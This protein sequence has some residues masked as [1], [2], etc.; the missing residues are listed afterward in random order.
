[1]DLTSRSALY[2]TIADKIERLILTEE[3][4]TDSKMPSE[5]YLADSFGVSR[6]VIREAL[7]LLRERGLITSRQGAATVITEPCTD[8]LARNLN[9]IILMKNV[10]PMQVY[11]IRMV[12]EMMSIHQAA[13]RFTEKDIEELCE[14]NGDMIKSKSDRTLRAELDMAFHKRIADIAENPLLSMMLDAVGTLMQPLIISNLEK[15]GDA[16]KG[17]ESHRQI[18]EAIRSGNGELAS[19]VMKDHLTSSA[20]Y[21]GNFAD[22]IFAIPDEQKAESF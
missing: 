16:D 6:P 21:Y 10:T 22:S 19:G 8:V 7:K 12:L 5:Q 20:Q 3:M 13:E 18:I 4:Q 9:R 2:E 17:D 1:M 15:L 14:L 11:Q